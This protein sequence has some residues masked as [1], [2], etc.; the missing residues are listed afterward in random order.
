MLEWFKVNF[1]SHIH[2]LYVYYQY[3]TKL[4]LFPSIDVERTCAKVTKM[5]FIITSS[6]YTNCGCI[7]CN[8]WLDL[9][10]H[11]TLLYKKKAYTRTNAITHI[12]S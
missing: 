8:L 1:V 7:D 4:F 3:S 2:K 6:L 10:V 12:S 9:V 5:V 11:V